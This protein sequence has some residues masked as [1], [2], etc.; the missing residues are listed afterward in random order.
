MQA[1][2]E[3]DK[4]WGE[5]GSVVDARCD[6]LRVTQPRVD[7]EQYGVDRVDLVRTL[8]GFFLRQQR[9]V[10]APL[11]RAITGLPAQATIAVVPEPSCLDPRLEFARGLGE[12]PRA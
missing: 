3:H 11:D 9:S 7:G 1:P 4:F 12:R 5:I 8:R 10:D 6:R 2:S